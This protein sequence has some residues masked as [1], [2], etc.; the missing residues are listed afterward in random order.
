MALMLVLGMSA[1]NFQLTL[2]ALAKTVF[3][4]GAASFGLFTT[5]LAVGALAGALA[6]GA[7][8]GRPSVYAVSSA[9]DRVRRVR[10][11][12]SASRRRTGWWS[13]LLVP[14]G[15]FMIYFAQAANQRIQLGVD[16]AFRGRVMA[17]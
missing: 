12:W 9:G 6:G 2:A 10:R 17:L 7:R 13:V 4:T 11:R 1:F 5:A 16:A 8:R 3:H 14:T 15:F